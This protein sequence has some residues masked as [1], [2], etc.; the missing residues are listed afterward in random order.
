MLC[1]AAGGKEE[2]EEEEEEK[3]MGVQ[4]AM[5][6]VVMLLMLLCVVYSSG[7][8]SQEET[9]DAR[10]GV[11]RAAATPPPSSGNA[12]GV[13]AGSGQ[14]RTGIA[15]EDTLRNALYGTSR[16]SG[17]SRSNGTT[18]S[19]VSRDEA[20][21]LVSREEVA[22]RRSSSSSSS[23]SYKDI[24]D[25]S[26]DL[27]RI[28]RSTVSSADISGLHCG[29]R[30]YDEVE[31]EMMEVQRA[32]RK[33]DAR[34]RQAALA[35][36]RAAGGGVDAALAVQQQ[37]WENLD[38]FRLPNVKVNF[39]IIVSEQGIGRVPRSSL[40]CTIARL[41]VGFSNR[42]PYEAFW[43]AQSGGADSP[44]ICNL[45]VDNVDSY[46]TPEEE[47][48]S[49]GP[50]MGISFAMGEVFEYA[51][52]CDGSDSDP[53]GCT[54][55]SGPLP[56]CDGLGCYGADYAMPTSYFD[57][58]SNTN[59]LEI[60]TRVVATNTETTEPK[61]HINVF[62]CNPNVG[63]QPTLGYVLCIGG[64]DF[65]FGF[66]P[67][68]ENSP[69]QAVFGL[70][71]TFPG[72]DFTMP[73]F[74]QA[75]TIVHEVGHLLGL[76]HTFGDVGYSRCPTGDCDKSGDLVCD[77]AP[78]NTP[79]FGSCVDNVG[80][81]DCGSSEEI[82]YSSFMNYVHDSCM[83]HFTPGQVQR[84]QETIVEFKPSL[85]EKYAPG[86]NCVGRQCV[87]G[88]WSEWSDCVPESCVIE[89]NI[90]VGSQS[91][92][93]QSPSDV[94]RSGVSLVG[95]T[96]G[97]SRS[98][99]VARSAVQPP[100]DGSS[101]SSSSSSDEDDGPDRRRRTLLQTSTVGR[102]TR[103]VS[104]VART[105]TRT[106]GA[107]TATASTSTSSSDPFA[108]IPPPPSFV[109]DNEE[110]DFP[111][112]TSAIL[113]QGV[114]VRSK[115]VISSPIGDLPSDQCVGDSLERR[116]CTLDTETVCQCPSDKIGMKIDLA[117]GGCATEASITVRESNTGTIVYSITR[118]V[119]GGSETEAI[120]SLC[121]RPNI[122]LVKISSNRCRRRAP[123][124]D[125]GA[126]VPGCPAGVVGY[127]IGTVDT[128]SGIIDSISNV[129]GSLEADNTVIQIGNPPGCHAGAWSDW[130]GCTAYCSARRSLSRSRSTSA[131]RESGIAQS[132]LDDMA[133]FATLNATQIAAS[134]RV[135]EFQAS[136]PYVARALR[137]SG[138]VPAGRVAVDARQMCIFLQSHS[139]LPYACS[140]Y[141]KSAELRIE[142]VRPVS[143]D[144]VERLVSES[145][146]DRNGVL[147]AGE[148]SNFMQVVGHNSLSGET[149]RR[150]GYDSLSLGRIGTRTRTRS[151]VY[152]NPSGIAGDF[153]SLSTF[154]TEPCQ[155]NS[156]S[157]VGGGGGGG[158]GGGIFT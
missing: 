17:S 72:T 70:Y 82:A 154:E 118:G 56:S 83:D 15:R 98:S 27:T 16:T 107:S 87:L 143:M 7:V 54:D 28:G 71:T 9:G 18:R 63:G 134:S 130:D 38:A 157:C 42:D 25:D 3:G 4:G 150:T 26:G 76:F 91:V 102:T 2:E 29:T 153:C 142:G 124:N 141:P 44:V 37:P 39:H 114:Q 69:G 79:A 156:F 131:L 5:Q 116:S 32:A 108:N 43:F 100:P 145:D 68:G 12:N 35:T 14:V 126:V 89:N 23:S 45:D 127:R 19:V 59:A 55:T 31:V 90:R 135:P 139:T 94:L 67:I 57:C 40:E 136:Y 115:E 8:S 128:G 58:R 106:S 88:E 22:R 75:D 104:R 50:Q 158:G 123:G 52:I 86:G 53:A 120:V 117:L 147:D 65:T 148:L 96:R 112:E 138:E 36:Q 121:L 95:R 122:Y 133:R 74:N 151:I 155:T 80:V 146:Y 13:E 113:T 140:G 105:G 48:A 81:T 66:C 30:H 10:V 33:L 62:S 92:L 129:C 84:M 6:T 11:A 41:N 47:A 51:A 61:Y 144:F 77:T 60:S 34:A 49:F 152:N 149:A 93:V 78:E 109:N 101:S 24:I 125:A 99:V 111:A 1:E 103:A 97:V 110:D 21:E 20:Y 119:I 132:L 85:C 64:D 46:L 73:E 137:N